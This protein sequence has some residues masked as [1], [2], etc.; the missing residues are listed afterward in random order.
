M[1]KTRQDFDKKKGLVVLLSAVCSAVLAIGALPASAADFTVTTDVDEL[2]TNGLCS[3]REAIVNA[4]DNALT[5]P[6]CPTGTRSST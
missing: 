6:D 2:T 1:M 5:Y 3:L 4:N